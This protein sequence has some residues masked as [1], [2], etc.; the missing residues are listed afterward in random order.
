MGRGSE[1][2]RSSRRAIG[3]KLLAAPPVA[4]G[5][6]RPSPNQGAVGHDPQEELPVADRRPHL[7]QPR[8]PRHD[9][10]I[11]SAGATIVD[12]AVRR[13]IL[14]STFARSR[15]SVAFLATSSARAFSTVGAEFLERLLLGVFQE[16]GLL[17]R[18]LL[19]G[20]LGLDRG[21]ACRTSICD[22][23]MRS[24]R[25]A[26]RLDHSSRSSGASPGRPRPARSRPGSSG[27]PA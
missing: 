7:D 12:L 14:R 16:H 15:S 6:R 26:I 22:F 5:R 24:L 19:E 20:E 3:P 9:E 23:V 21:R 10:T 4:T 18:R 11:P 8:R 25:R 27:G 2:G 17:G 1:R 13:S